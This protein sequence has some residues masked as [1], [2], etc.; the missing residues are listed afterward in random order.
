DPLATDATLL[1][2]VLDPVWRGEVPPGSL[3]ALVADAPWAPPGVGEAIM[4]RGL[5]AD[6]AGALAARARLLAALGLA[7]GAGRSRVLS[8]RGEAGS[9][10]G[11]LENLHGDRLQIIVSAFGANHR[12]LVDAWLRHALWLAS[13]EAD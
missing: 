3:D 5:A 9:L 7:D 12:S 11:R 10:T 1:Q 4:A 6:V 13:G 8:W 2:R